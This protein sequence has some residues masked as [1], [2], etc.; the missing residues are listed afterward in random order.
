MSSKISVIVL[1]KNSQKHIR[2]CIESILKQTYPDFEVIVVDAQSKDETLSILDRY[3][4][5][6]N[7]PFRIERVPPDTSIGKARQ[8]G[9]EIS[10]GEILAF[11]D[12]DVELPHENWLKNMSEP[13]K[14]E[15]V[16]GV[17]TLAKC[18][19]TDP[20]IL[21]KIHSSFEYKNTVIDINH[22]EIVGTSHLLIRKGLIEK[23]GGIRDICSSED[24]EVTKKIMQS[25]YKFI[26]LPTEKCYHY[27]VDGY[28]HYIKKEIRNKKLA[29][30][31][32]FL[33]RE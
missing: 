20:A 29:I 9:L 12:S 11:I 26:Y 24:L 10:N 31:R 33:E 1:T 17:Q 2:Q 28:W 25:G 27:H 15:T 8:I 7:L 16:A 13:L 3:K 32:I 19:D 5:K 4:N 18:K 14:D 22:Y 21:K 6:T 30:R 23:V